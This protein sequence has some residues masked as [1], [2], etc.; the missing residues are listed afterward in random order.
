MSRAITIALVIFVL[1]VSG[2]ISSPTIEKIKPTPL[3]LPKPTQ[4]I[5]QSE[6]S[7]DNKF[8]EVTVQLWTVTTY[9]RLVNG[10][11]VDTYYQGRTA[12]EGV[13]NV[14]IVDA[15]GKRVY[16]NNNTI[17]AAD[18]MTTTNI[19]NEIDAD[20]LF[21]RFKGYQFRIPINEIVKSTKTLGVLKVSLIL[22][23]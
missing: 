21:G 12:V 4:L 10:T 1:L 22:P 7:A 23:E 3:K 8:A 17:K 11:I 13:L 19:T 20:T 9:P 15:D 16:W 5:V 14:E 6:P 2:C 18:L